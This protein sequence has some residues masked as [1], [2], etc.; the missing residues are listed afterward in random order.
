MSTTI[1]QRVVSMEF[2]NK[3]FERNVATSMSTLEKLKQSLNLSGATKGLENV[4]AAAKKCNLSPLSSA[5]E[6]VGL[7]FNAMYTIADQAFRNITNSAMAAGKQIVAA[8]SIE[9]IKAGLA[10][11]E[12]QIG[13]IQTILANTQSK[14]TNLD[15]VNGALDELNTYADKTIYNFTEMTKNIGTFTAAGVGL[16]ESVAAIKGIANLAAISGSTSHQASTA[17]YQLSQALASG[18]VKLMDWNSV[19]NA[20]MGGEVFQTALKRTATQMGYNVDA[21]IEKYGSF[22]ESLTQG[23]WLTADVLTETLA[24]LSGAYTEADLLAQGYSEKQ[25]KEIVQLAQT[26]ESAATDVK[27]Y[28]QLVDTMKESL[29]SGWTQTWEIL[30]GDFEEAKEL[31]SGVSKVFGD[32][33]NDSS[34]ARNQLL[35]KALGKST[36]GEFT[37]KI[38]EAGVSTEEFAETV[39]NTAKEHG[40]DIDSLVEKYGSFEKAIQAGAVE[41]DILKKSLDAFGKTTEKFNLDAIDRTLKQGMKGDDIKE[42]EKALKSLGY[43]LV[44]KDGK[45][46]SGDGVFGSLTE[47]AIKDFQKLNGLKVTGLIDQATLDALDA[48]CTKTEKL[49]ESVYDLVE[50]FGNMGGREKIIEGISNAFEGLKNV[51]APIKDAFR[52][53]FPPTT[54]EQLYG[55]VD[56]FSN[57]TAKFKE[58]T[59]S[60]QGQEVIGNIASAFKG[61][62]SVI[63]IGWTFVKDLAGGIADLLGSVLGLGGGIVKAAG[64]LGEWL[65]GLRDS[66]KEGDYFGKTIDSIV[67]FL[68]KVIDKVKSVSSFLKEKLVA[69]GWEGFVSILSSIWD[70]IQKIGSKIAEVGSAIGSVIGNAFRNGDIDAGLDILNGGI[71]ATT[72]LSIKKFFGGL[73]DTASDG[74]KNVLGSVGDALE[75]WQQNLQAGTLTKIAGAI[76]LLAAS[77]LVLAS[78]DPGK[79]TASLGA[80][81][82][83]FADLVGS[84]KLL[85]MFSGDMKNMTSASVAMA[86][87]STSILILASALKKLSGLSWEDL[88]KGIIGV[89]GL[90]AIMVVA[91]KA[92]S[93]NTQ[94]V[95]KG[96][97]QM[98]LFAAAIKI[99]ASVCEDLGA[100]SWEELGKGL[101][102]VGVLLAE[103]AIFMNNAKFSGKSISTALG[104]TILAGAIKILAS[105]CKDFG[106]M[107]WGE[108]G[109][110]LASV[111]A[112][113]LELGLF[114]KLTGNAKNTIS[115]GIALVAIAGAMKIFASTITDLSNLSWGQLGI[116]LAG[117][118][119][120]LLAVAIAVNLMPTNMI[121]TG[122][123]LV[124]VGASL[125]LVANAMKQM[126]DMSWGE[127]GKSLVTLGGSMLILAVG[128]NAMTGTL[129][130]SAALL[131]AAAALAILT[132]VLT[133]LGSMGLGSIAKS[134][135]TVA[136]AFAV[137]GVAGLLLGPLV[138]AMLGV[139][140]AFALLGVA[141]LAVGVGLA[142][143]A[144]GITALAVSGAAAGSAI[145]SFCKA[146]T[147]SIVEIGNMIKALVLTIVD[148]LVECIPAIA[149]GAL[150]LIVGVLDALVEYTPLIVDG[151]MEFLIS[152]LDSVAARTP[153]LVGSVMNVV[154]SLLVAVADAILGLDG[155]TL[156]KAAIGVAVMTALMGMFSVL[157]PMV[158]GAML[159]IL[160]LGAV[161]AELAA[162][163]A[164]VG[165]L[166]QIPGLTWLVGEGG[167]LLEAVGNSLGRLVGGLVGGIAQGI[168]SSLP[169]IGTDLSSFMK[170]VK[171]FLDGAAGINQEAIDGVGKLVNVITAISGAS[172]LE[173][174][175]SWITGGSS[176]TTFAEQLVPFGTAMKSF[177]DAISGIDA[178]AVTAAANAGSALTAMADTIPNTGGLVSFFTGDNDMATFGTQLVAYGSSLKKFASS[179]SGIDTEAIGAAATASASLTTFAQNIPNTGGLVTFFTGDNDMT[180]FGT[181]LV[182]Y[183]SSLKS[184]AT[185]VSGIDTDALSTI[186]TASSS[187]VTFANQIPNTGGLI[188]FFT[189]DNDMATFG[190]Q[191]VSYGTALKSFA[192]SVSGIDTDALTTISTAS[193]SLV[194]FAENIPNTGGLVDFF[195]GDNDMNTFGT[196][197]VS[198]GSSLKN[199][200]ISVSGI[201]TDALTT[202]A[203]A[204][205]SLVSLANTIPN[206]G[207]LV[208][209]FTGDNDM[210]TFG[211]QLVSFGTALKNFASSVS[212]IDAEA[213]SAIATA[214]TDLTTLAN[215]IPNT[216]G[217]VSFFTGDSDMSTFGTQLVSFGAGIKSFATSVSGIDAEALAAIASACV[218]LGT[219][220]NTIPNTGGLVSF[221]TGDSDMGTFGTQ[222]VSFGTGVKS[223]ADSV[224][225]VNAD[226]LAAIATASTHLVSLANSIPN[227]G[228]LVTFFTGDNDMDTFGTQLVSFGTSIK[229]FSDA[230]AGINIEAITAA[231][232]AG[233]AL[234]NLAN[235]IPETGGLF[236]FFTGDNSM[237]DFGNQIKKFGEGLAGFATAVS[238][239]DVGATTSATTIA[240]SLNTLA[241]TMTTD[242]NIANLS[243]YGESIKDFGKDI[244][245]F[246]DSISKINTTSLSSIVTSL[247]ELSSISATDSSGLSTFVD[248]LGN[249]GTEGLNAFVS[250]FDGAASRVQAAGT[251]LITTL[252]SAFDGSAS[253]IRNSGN[254]LIT[255][256]ISAFDSASGRMQSTGTKL[257]TTLIAAFD[258]ANGPMQNV[259]TKLVVG[260]VTIFNNAVSRMQDAGN[261]IILGFIAGAQ[262]ASSGIPIAFSAFVSSALDSVTSAYSGFYNAGGYLVSGFASGIT[263]NRFRAMAA[264]SAMASAALSAAKSALGIASPSKEFYK[265]GSFAG[266]GLVN[267]LVNYESITYKAGVSIAESAKSGLSNAISN[268]QNLIDGEVDVQPTIRPVVDLS[269]VEASAGVIN[270]MFGMTPSIG[271][272]SSLGS[273]SHMMTKNQNGVSNSDVVS[274][275]KDL[276]RKIGKTSGDTY[277]VNGVTY[278]D[279]SNINEAVKTLVRA[280]RVERRK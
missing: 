259:G 26:A 271:V 280:A 163:L 48:A 78:I 22:R 207:G 160:G 94:Q 206:T 136:A 192:M 114:T 120:A 97:T 60:A 236:S 47:E 269:D 234:S 178:E 92:L 71:L 28:T 15:D 237:D 172:L 193:T 115:T 134:L 113:L 197:L 277:N 250:A 106:Q 223:F 272:L 1:D 6:T 133:T 16:D 252:I 34:N 137:I 183:G 200:A 253:R 146:I 98:V 138:P 244:K 79:L 140:G 229:G 268:V 222:L 77:I 124:V 62:F 56:G 261:K 96:A 257:I 176:M 2:D 49:D 240:G 3:Q 278:D 180:T 170:N 191:L 208:S 187:L 255:T 181:Q 64:A 39:K 279:G 242:G 216:G 130:G 275:I 227:T 274:A 179:V 91:A 52:D 186:A 89:A 104:I 196:Q 110:G 151:I 12:T 189:G 18:T 215:S 195:T 125:L 235:T 258:S 241:N 128:L 75:S 225:G 148:V 228:G 19:V 72:L 168:T 69:P 88:A 50:G 175:T 41:T 263:A 267:A 243:S 87:M 199:F 10:E 190:T 143:A 17:M 251:K 231:A 117:L 127:I 90:S 145:V 152:A 126:S 202:I 61:F 4:E 46:Y 247:T 5:V 83:L 107:A 13:A 109:K 55:M 219:I 239:I 150:K 210:A 121:S 108:I 95:M 132:P 23:E 211:T 59:A 99:L 154:T 270:G 76:A 214:S 177:A 162:V 53:I 224:S 119:G 103:V 67:S 221:F 156:A 184:F 65:S 123:G 260:F 73:G 111:G 36:W 30:I 51:V 266:E 161:I 54:A 167:V 63:D 166:A 80:I 171:P 38:N 86:A 105:A 185:S 188:S 232:N 57:L 159:G 165:A 42:V 182:A 139:A 27:T 245:S 11:Y 149:D 131:V 20:G 248:S 118:A 141:A 217:L 276:G 264:A 157:A 21:M 213:L 153:E 129:A 116:G 81:T 155:T 169:Q 85:T 233:T 135:I 32:M 246:Y 226:A 209:F 147:E 43:D 218:D 205:S 262:N 29:Q 164:A 84:L 142:A 25:A 31:W 68:Q 74:I 230:V 82:V 14:G 112:L 254:K 273:I 100:L 58:W 158:P 174:V 144:T 45:D 265:I 256:L 33:I 35:E 173:S 101:L 7:K 122:L 201:D 40:K 66:I 212:G 102:G 198:Y 8:I 194:S 238:G 70:F 24:Q 44:G 249:V 203:T 93:S 9:P 204:S 220:A 37:E